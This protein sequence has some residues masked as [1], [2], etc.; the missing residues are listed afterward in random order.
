M[1][2]RRLFSV[3]NA[4]LVLAVFVG[5]AVVAAPAYAQPRKPNVVVIF[6][7][8]MG[9]GDAGLPTAAAKPASA[10][11]AQHQ[12]NR[13]SSRAASRSGM[14]RPVAPQ[15]ARRSSPGRSRSARPCRS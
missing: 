11:H 7:D 1:R 4:A 14:R 6:C 12:Q 9:W 8:D 13:C 10:P 2:L 5:T 15:A 3:C